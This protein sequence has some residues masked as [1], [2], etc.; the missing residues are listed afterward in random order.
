MANRS[1]TPIFS[2]EAS[3]PSRENRSALRP[4]SARDILNRITSGET[5]SGSATHSPR[6][7]LANSTQEHVDNQDVTPR[8]R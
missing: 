8:S 6:T 5:N 7:P 4:P 3:T 2:F 1:R